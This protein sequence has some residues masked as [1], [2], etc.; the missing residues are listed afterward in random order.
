[1]KIL[2]V[3][4]DSEFFGLKIGKIDPSEFNKDDFESQ[5]NN[6]DL[7]YLFESPGSP[8]NKD[9]VAINAHLV[10]E[11]KTYV[12]QVDS[13][14]KM[15]KHINVY[16]SLTPDQNLTRLSLQSGIYSRFKL[17]KN[18]AP[19]AYEKLYGEWIKKSCNK[20]MS[21]CVL[22]YGN[23]NDPQGFITIAERN[24]EAQIGLIAVD[25][26]SRGKGIGKKLITAAEY[27]AEN[28]N[29][30]S[31]KVV[32]QGANTDACKLYEKCGFTL[33]H[34]INIYHYWNKD[35]AHTL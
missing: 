32:T 1:M 23:E 18:F 34:A 12:K 10:D 7:I 13:N 3:I 8:L 35:N 2:P 26:S 31:L 22:V 19:G 24:G 14:I 5:K 11:K 9:I 4:W 27:T 29:F 15:D 21:L 33:D 17:D 28:Y 30:G 20:S 25:D 16:T 6:F